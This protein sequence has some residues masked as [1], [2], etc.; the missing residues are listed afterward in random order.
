[1]EIIRDGITT[2]HQKYGEFNSRQY[3]VRLETGEQV[4]VQI[5]APDGQ[6]LIEKTFT[7]QYINSHVNVQWQDKG[8]K[9][10]EE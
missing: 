2:E 1:M 7:A 3:I 6:L 9:K 10:L 4:T 5:K 8:K